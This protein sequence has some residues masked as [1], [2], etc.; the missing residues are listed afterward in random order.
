[1]ADMGQLSATPISMKGGLILNEDPFTQSPSTA[2]TLVNFEPSITGG[3]R[4]ID[5]YT[6]FNALALTGT[7][8]ILGVS[9]FAGEVVACR[10]PNMYTSNG[11]SSWS[12][13]T[14]TRT[15]A[16]FYTFVN[17]H[18]AAA[19]ILMFTD[20][21][22]PAG[23]WDGSV[24]STVTDVNAPSA[25]DLC[26][27]FNS[28]LV[29]TEGNQLYLSVPFAETDF[30]PGS[31]AVQF[32]LPGPITAVKK[33]RQALYVFGAKYIRKLTGFGTSS[34]QME[35]V[36]DS[37]GCTASRSIQEIGGDLLFLAE[38]GLRNIAGT[39]KIGD[40]EMGSISQSIQ[41]LLS[42]SFIPAPSGNYVC[43]AVIR[44]KSQ[45]RLY[46]PVAGQDEADTLGII[47]VI[48]S[49]GWQFSTMQGIRASCAD[50][51]LVGTTYMVVHGGFDGFVYRQES[52]KLFDTL[53][54][55][56][57]FT[58]A[59]V[60]F[61]DAGIRN[62]LQR[63]IV[64]IDQEGKTLFNVHVNYNFSALDVPQPAPYPINLGSDLSS[65]GTGL[66]GTDMYADKPEG[67]L[68]IY[69]VSKSLFILLF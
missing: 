26:A 8:E 31:G 35:S 37:V 24:Y 5:G 4:K 15:S 44:D 58:T 9:S 69:I 2:T 54:I 13:I 61:G 64:N 55:P 42:A 16:Q 45:Y 17:F 56:F 18:W 6:K 22:N 28:S 25:P 48:T 29:L 14:L 65:Y 67:L 10:G 52:G 12:A 66:Y 50:D 3:Y 38:D 53:A 23:R 34:Y 7:G 21:V 41:T 60:M 68:L 47:A 63:L 40:V 46:I 39:D 20:S 51:V 59:E 57:Q 30:T 49:E 33:F 1:M 19:E 43:S 32:A 36:T 11:A 62:E 27:E